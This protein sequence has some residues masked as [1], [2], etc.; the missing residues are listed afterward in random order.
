MRTRLALRLWGGEGRG[1]GRG[2]RSVL[3]SSVCLCMCVFLGASEYMHPVSSRAWPFVR[4]N[5]LYVLFELLYTRKRTGKCT[6]QWTTNDEK[7]KQA[8]LT[9]KY[10]RQVKE[11][12]QTTTKRRKKH[13]RGQTRRR[14]PNLYAVKKKSQPVIHTNELP[15]S[16]ILCNALGVKSVRRW[17]SKHAACTVH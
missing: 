12:R 10:L 1:G 5:D 4:L 14:Q 2:G 13:R 17:V 16:Y 8:L 6:H 3:E 7:N 9:L 15:V 11:E